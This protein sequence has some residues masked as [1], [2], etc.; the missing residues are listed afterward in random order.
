[1]RNWFYYST[2]ITS[3]PWWMVSDGQDDCTSLWFVVQ[4]V[5]RRFSVAHKTE[6]AGTATTDG[7]RAR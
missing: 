3:L 5:E 6:A 1:M 4:F 2:Q 7:W